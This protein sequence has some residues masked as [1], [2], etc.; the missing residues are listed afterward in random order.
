MPWNREAALVGATLL[1]RLVKRTPDGLASHVRELVIKRLAAEII[2]QVAAHET[3][4][5]NLLTEPGTRFFLDRA[6]LA[7]SSSALDVRC[8]LRLPLAAIGAPVGAYFPEVARRL[9]AEL[10]IPELT[11]VGNAIGAASGSIVETVE[12]LV[13]PEYA[14]TGIVGYRAHT[15]EE[16]HEFVDRESALAY[17]RASGRR[18]ALDAARRAGADEVVVEE[19]CTDQQGTVAGDSD[20]SLYLG[21]RLRF[22]AVGRPRVTADEG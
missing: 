15:P 19:E 9:G 8:Q 14:P 1:C 16:R 7:D 20:G 4:S 10:L 21:S 2:S 6:L 5:D 17:A 13:A 11:G 12:V 22:T 18:L 3:G